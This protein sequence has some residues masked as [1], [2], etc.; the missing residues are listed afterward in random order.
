MGRIH[1]RDRSWGAA[2]KVPDSFLTCLWQQPPI[3][4]IRYVFLQQGYILTL[5]QYMCSI[6]RPNKNVI[7]ICCQAQEQVNS[8]YCYLP[9]PIFLRSSSSVL[10]M[11][12]TASQS[13]F[14]LLVFYLLR[15]LC[16]F[17]ITDVTNYTNL[18]VQRYTNY[19]AVCV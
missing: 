7:E 9:C 13:G 11:N 4:F 10:C 18:V 1:R 12:A 5:L 17:L 8:R 3:Q 19:H 15:T 6:I 16:Q 14:L 2:L